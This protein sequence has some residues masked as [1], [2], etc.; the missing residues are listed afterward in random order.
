MVTEIKAVKKALRI[1]EKELSTE[2]Y[3]EFL[4]AITP[5]FKFDSTKMLRELTKDLSLDEVFSEVK[6]REKA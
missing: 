4:R 1:L 6:K 2:E 3:I 5:R